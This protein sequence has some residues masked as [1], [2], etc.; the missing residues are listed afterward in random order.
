MAICRPWTCW[1]PMAAMRA[2]RST[3]CW[4]TWASPRA[5]GRLPTGAWPWSASSSP[6]TRP[7]SP[8]ASPAST[9]WATSTATPANASAS[10]AAFTR[11]R[12]PP[13]SSPSARRATSCPWN[14]PPAASACRPGWAWLAPPAEPLHCAAPTIQAHM[15]SIGNTHNEALAPLPA[16][17]RVFRWHD[18]AS[19]W[20]SL[21]VGLLVMQ[22]GAYLVPALGTQQA[23]AAY[24]WGQ[25]NV[26]RAVERNQRAGLPTTYEA[27]RMPDETRNYVPKLQA[28]KNIVLRPQDFSIV[29]PTIRNHPYFLSVPIADR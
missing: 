8:P 1:A 10:C 9:P 23:L 2:C 26:Q 22:V 3:C 15:N 17:Q 16:G 25:G 27:L 18:H 7:R 21:G 20:F 11:R 24:N 14:T 12:W 29:L 19:L 13:S 28:V 4:P 5:W 6:W